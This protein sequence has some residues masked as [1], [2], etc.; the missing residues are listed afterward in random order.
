[1]RP[2]K[3]FR[4]ANVSTNSA[5]HGFPML[6]SLKRMGTRIMPSGK[7]VA[8]YHSDQL[9]TTIILPLVFPDRQ[10]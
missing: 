6:L 3:K 9:E 2:L 8:E 5:Q 10:E 1:M 7:A 4:A